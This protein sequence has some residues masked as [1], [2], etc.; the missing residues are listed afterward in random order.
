[1]TSV[2]LIDTSILCELLEV[3]GK[4]SEIAAKKIKETF[5]QLVQDDVW[6]IL[7]LA[8]VIETGN[9]IA[10]N[11]DGVV[12]RNKGLLLKSFVERSMR[13]DSPFLKP[14]FWNSQDLEAWMKEFPDAAMRKVG[15]G[16]VSIMRDMEIAK[17]RLQLPSALSIE[18]W[19][20]DTHLSR[21][22]PR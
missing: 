10:Q 15:L 14:P 22:V 2:R 17:E 7:P 9:H 8:A 16:D 3:P 1:M 12:R 4:S 5:A 20:K 6:F 13:Q 19:S 11:G 21:T 18:I